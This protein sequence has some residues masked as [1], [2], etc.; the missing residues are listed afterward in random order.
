MLVIMGTGLRIFLIHE[1]N[2]LQRL[3]VSRYERL[4]RRERNESHPEYAGKQIR[5]AIAILTLAGRKPL[6]IN[7]IDYSVLSFDSEGRIDTSDQE[8]QARLALDSLPPLTKDENSED[9]G[10]IID[11]RQRFAKKRYEH[12]YKWRPNPATEAAII[13]AIFGNDPS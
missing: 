13:A 4:I 9:R 12:Q 6:A 5:Y 11:A 7:R 10:Q 1:H 8:K 2:N 3:S